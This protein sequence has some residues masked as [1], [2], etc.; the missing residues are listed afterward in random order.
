MTSIDNVLRHAVKNSNKLVVTRQLTAFGESFPKHKRLVK[1][2]VNR[3][4]TLVPSRKSMSESVVSP[5]RPGQKGSPTTEYLS[6]IRLPY[7]K[8]KAFR[9]KDYNFEPFVVNTNDILSKRDEFRRW[10]TDTSQRGFIR[11]NNNDESFFLEARTVG[12]GENIRTIVSLLPQSDKDISNIKL[13]RSLTSCVV[14]T[15]YWEN[16]QS[17]LDY[18]YYLVSDARGP[19]VKEIKMACEDEFPEKNLAWTLF[20]FINLLGGMTTAILDDK[21]TLEAVQDICPGL[22]LTPYMLLKKGYSYYNEHGFGYGSGNTQ[23]GVTNLIM[24]MNDNQAK[25]IEFSENQRWLWSPVRG[26]FPGLEVPLKITEDNCAYIK[27]MIEEAMKII[28]HIADGQYLIKLYTYG[29][30]HRGL[31]TFNVASG[32]YD[33]KEFDFEESLNRQKPQVTRV[34]KVIRPISVDEIQLTTGLI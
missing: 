19:H 17:E 2:Y 7:S 23:D 27:S 11:V 1:K 3:V 30:S 21:A 15:L 25:L 4:G 24:T 9:F 26:S 33:I 6:S 34:R 13:R 16:L 29:D 32:T 20:D 28:G 14:F 31:L 18:F 10:C 22:P 5:I 8:K 12:A